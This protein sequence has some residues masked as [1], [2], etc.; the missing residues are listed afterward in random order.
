MYYPS[1][2]RTSCKKQ[3]CTLMFNKNSD[4]ENNEKSFLFFAGL[5]LIVAC[6]KDNSNHAG[7]WVSNSKQCLYCGKVLR[8]TQQMAQTSQLTSNRHL[9]MPKQQSRICST[10][11]KGQF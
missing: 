11:S 1:F 4:Y 9:M 5:C 10:T 2:G 7:L 6:N 3:Q 8:F